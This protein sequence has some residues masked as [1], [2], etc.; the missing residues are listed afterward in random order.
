[1]ED[2][3]LFRDHNGGPTGLVIAQCAQEVPFARIERFRTAPFKGSRV[4]ARLFNSL[5]VFHRFIRFNCEA[6]L[7]LIPGLRA[8]SPAPLVYVL[9]FQG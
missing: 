7:K 4:S 8:I 1:L 9:N 5:G 6:R 3:S 2:V